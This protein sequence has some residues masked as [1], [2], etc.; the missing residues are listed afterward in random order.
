M[1]NFEHL[2]LVVHGIGGYCDLRFRSLPECVDDM[3]SI[4]NRFCLE[5]NNSINSTMSSLYAGDS[6]CKGIEFLP[7]QWHSALHCGPERLNEKL[8]KISLSSCGKIRDF[9]ND[10]LLDVL[11]FTSPVYHKVIFHLSLLYSI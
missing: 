1:E 5:P 8:N 4:S 7:I 2:V 11:L 10:V 6:S 9:V 3:R